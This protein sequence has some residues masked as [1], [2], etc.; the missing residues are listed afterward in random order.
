[1]GTPRLG[2]K[3]PTAKIETQTGKLD[4]PGAKADDGYSVRAGAPNIGNETNSLEPNINPCIH[5]RQLKVPIS[6]T[7]TSF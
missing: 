6:V 4:T 2:T 3:T 1:M 5:N 7:I